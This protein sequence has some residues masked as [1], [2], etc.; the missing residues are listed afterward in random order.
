MYYG[1]LGTNYIQVQEYR[2]VLRSCR[3]QR[4][5]RFNMHMYGKTPIPIIMQK[6]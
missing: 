3:P 1:H 5:N 4:L 6:L 2:K